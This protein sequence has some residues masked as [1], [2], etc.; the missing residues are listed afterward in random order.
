[1]QRYLA[2][3]QFLYLPHCIEGEGDEMC[4]ACCIIN[5]HWYIWLY[6]KWRQTTKWNRSASFGTRI[7]LHSHNNSCQLAK[8]SAN[9]IKRYECIRE[10]THKSSTM[11][12]LSSFHSHLVICEELS[13]FNQHLT[14]LQEDS[15][16]DCF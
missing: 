12:V 3:R 13:P 7:Q 2:K 5:I 1:M 9:S 14:C 6:M 11:I 8:Y 16:N 4:H 15:S 10:S